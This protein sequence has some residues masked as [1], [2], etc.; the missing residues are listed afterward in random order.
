MSVSEK[1]AARRN[2]RRK[3]GRKASRA[4][5]VAPLSSDSSLDRPASGKS[6][7]AMTIAERSRRRDRQRRFAPALSRN[8]SRHR[9]AVARR[10]AAACR[11]I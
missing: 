7:L 10:S 3:S 4:R 6:A 5:Q 8:G 11:I 1:S 9:E 2:Q